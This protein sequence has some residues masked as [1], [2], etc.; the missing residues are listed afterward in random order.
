[1]KPSRR[2]TAIACV[3]LFVF[4]GGTVLTLNRVDQLRTGSTLEEVLYISSP[5][6]LKRL[7]MGYEGLLADIYWTRAV[8]YFGNKHHIGAEHYNLLA[9]LLEITTYLDPH[10]VV[11]YQFG[12]NFLSPKPPD[13]AGMPERAVTL[14]ENGI[15]AK[16]TPDFSSAERRKIL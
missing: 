12:S 14:M 4:L 3:L 11:A 16:F 7:S 5:K 1:M 9:P 2:I 6:V 10:L 8:Q 15:R 13:G